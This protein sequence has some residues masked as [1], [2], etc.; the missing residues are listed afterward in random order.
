MLSRPA[1]SSHLQSARYVARRTLTEITV[2][3]EAGM[4][5]A[6]CCKFQCHLG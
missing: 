1:C 5:W 3:M 6:C 2:E 4:E